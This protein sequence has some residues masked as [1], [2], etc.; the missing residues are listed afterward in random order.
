MTVG[1]ERQGEDR[2]RLSL[3]DRGPT[4]V[5][6]SQTRVDPSPPITR[7]RPS[8]AN[9]IAWTSPAA[10]L[11]IDHLRPSQVLEPDV[12]RPLAHGRAL[13]R[14]EGATRSR[15]IHDPS[16]FPD[17]P[18]PVSQI[19]APAIAERRSQAIAGAGEGQVMYRASP[20]PPA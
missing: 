19:A 2:P 8:G 11:R 1:S 16:D 4:P 15:R 18:E 9:S 14:A 13:R 12:P 6:T 7:L 20:F 3:E 10:S 17:R 5:A